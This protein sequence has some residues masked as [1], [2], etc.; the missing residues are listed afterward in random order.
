[1]IELTM[2]GILLSLI[3]SLKGNQM[4]RSQDWT[5]KPPADTECEVPNMKMSEVGH[6]KLQS[7]FILDIVHVI[8][9]PSNPG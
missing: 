6:S 9:L 3:R 4:F 5:T 2:P 1:M 7:F 8:I